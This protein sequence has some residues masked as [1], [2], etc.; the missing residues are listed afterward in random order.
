[1]RSAGAFSHARHRRSAR[2]FS[3]CE[4]DLLPIRQGLDPPGDLG[5]WSN[6]PE[7]RHD[8][9]GSQTAH[10]AAHRGRCLTAIWRR[11]PPPGILLA[12]LWWHLWITLDGRIRV[13]VAGGASEGFIGGLRCGPSAKGIEPAD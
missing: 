12:V 4:L 5:R 13:M 3:G 1:M 2:R 9:P 8:S 11:W 7:K 10:R 6:G